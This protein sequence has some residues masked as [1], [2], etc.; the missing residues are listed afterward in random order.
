MTGRIPCCILNIEALGL[1]VSDWNI[2]SCISN[3]KP[4]SDNDTPGA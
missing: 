3:Y 1:V 2:F 4:I